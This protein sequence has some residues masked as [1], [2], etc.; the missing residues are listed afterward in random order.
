MQFC[1]HDALQYTW[2]RFLPLKNA[3]HWDPF[4]RKVVEQ[5]EQ[6]L[7]RK[8]VLRTRGR[9]VLRRIVDLRVRQPHSND[10]DGN[11][12]FE[13]LNPEIY[14]SDAYSNDDIEILRTVGLKNLAINQY[15]DLARSDLGSSSASR[16]R[17]PGTT[18][19]WHRRVAKLL[20]IPFVNSW[21]HHMDEVRAMG[22]IP[23]TGGSWVAAD[24]G[25]IHYPHIQGVPIPTD[26]SLRLVRPEAVEDTARRSLF[27]SLGVR[28]ADGT[29]VRGLIL[30]Q[31]NSNHFISLSTS[32]QHLRFLYLSHSAG[33]SMSSLLGS[34]LRIYDSLGS[35]LPLKTST[36]YTE[37]NHLYGAKQLLGDDG[38]IALDVSFIS[39]K[40][41]ETPP[42]KPEGSDMTWADWMHKILGVRRQVRLFDESTH[43]L[44]RECNYIAEHHPRHFLGYLQHV[45]PEQG[46]LVLSNQNALD[47]LRGVEV[48]CLKGKN[49]ALE[50]CYLPLPRLMEVA[51][52]F[53]GGDDLPFLRLPAA[54]NEITIMLDWAFLVN[55]LGVG[56]ED[57]L[58]FRLSLLSHI[59]EADDD[60]G[61][62]VIGLYSYIEASCMQA[63]HPQQLREKT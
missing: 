62:R 14:L 39:P 5:I 30:R 9:A 35:I 57:N 54:S 34:N 16:V 8:P 63:L 2:M 19:D 51:R 11:P 56:N 58:D 1:N 31:Y 15:L 43:S 25:G 49:V 18:D 22:I 41:F 29:T 12:L 46:S 13:D 59:Q 60:P 40:Y 52:R 26:L 6:L 38:A 10:Q 47:S 23:L 61:T 17:H 42:A 27:D 36:F 21:K 28:T 50:N 45:W 53:T 44:S 55:D 7:G 37:D 32:L 20:R 48:L 3:H 24:T 33:D 4:W